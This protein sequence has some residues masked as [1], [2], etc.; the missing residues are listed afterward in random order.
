MYAKTCMLF[1]APNIC[2]ALSLQ[3]P[4]LPLSTSLIRNSPNALCA[5]VVAS[6]PLQTA[7]VYQP[8]AKSPLCCTPPPYSKA[9]FCKSKP[10]HL[11]SP[12]T[13]NFAVGL[14]VPIPKSPAE[15]NLAASVAFNRNDIPSKADI[16]S[17]SGLAPLWSCT[18][19][20]G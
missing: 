2:E 5:D 15:S 19:I 16:A 20:E 17:P 13:C 9:P 4:C 10:V 1:P 14:V 8:T 3:E 12:F 6:R 7:N 11:M 18:V